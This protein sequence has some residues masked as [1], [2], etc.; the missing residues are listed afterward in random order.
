MKLI[1]KIGWSI[2]S[3]LIIFMFF[4]HFYTKSELKNDYVILT[5]KIISISSAHKSAPTFQ[6]EIFYN[7]E[8][9]VIGSNTNVVKENSFIGKYFPIVYSPRI[10]LGQILIT[11]EDF[12]A[13][14]IPFP[15]SLR[16]TLDFK[17]DK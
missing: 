17:Y 11:P 5:C 1:D 3:L 12:K 13:Y 15:D 2:F 10:N 16:W 9:K 8:R 6:C 4:W 14:N 7:R